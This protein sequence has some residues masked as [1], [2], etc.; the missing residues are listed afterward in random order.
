MRRPRIAH[1]AECAP[2]HRVHIPGCRAHSGRRMTFRFRLRFRLLCASVARNQRFS[3]NRFS[4]IE[5]NISVQSG[6]ISMQIVIAIVLAWDVNGSLLFLS[7]ALLGI[8]RSRS[9]AVRFSIPFSSAFRAHSLPHRMW[10][11]RRLQ[12][13]GH[14]LN[15]NTAIPIFPIQFA[16][17]IVHGCERI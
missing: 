3:S 12:I 4:S 9:A 15:A 13:G 1:R 10:R 16:F 5:P 6:P 7:T 11:C 17:C 2:R 8:V 14:H